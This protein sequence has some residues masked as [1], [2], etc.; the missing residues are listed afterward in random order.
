MD[1]AV[2]ELAEQQHG[3]FTLAQACASGFTRSAIA[4]RLSCG[5]WDLVG[6]GLY[7]LPGTPR[8]WEQRLSGLVLASGPG[9]GA[10]HRSAAALLGIP[11]FDRS[12]R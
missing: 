8:T 12:G 5:R 6:P 2:V 11:G 3:V 4:H 9:A 10:S 1:G 7:R